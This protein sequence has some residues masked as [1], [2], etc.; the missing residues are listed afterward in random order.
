VAEFDHRRNHCKSTDGERTIA[1]LRLA[2]GKRLTLK[3][4][5]KGVEPDIQ[6]RP[7]ILQFTKRNVTKPK[8]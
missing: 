4:M 2:E 6:N 3:P 8:P 7:R 5:K 1:A